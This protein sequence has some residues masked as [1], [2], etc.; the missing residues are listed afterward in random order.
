MRESRRVVGRYQLTREDV[1]AGRTFEDG[2]AR[3][4]WPIELWQEGRLGAATS[5]CR[6]GRRMTF[7]SA[8]CRRATST[9]SSSPAGA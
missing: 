4:S 9:I 6:M 7:R 8:A 1:L 2:V 3:A 5:T